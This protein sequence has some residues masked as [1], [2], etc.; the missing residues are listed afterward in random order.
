LIA[1]S[2]PEKTAMQKTTVLLLLAITLLGCQPVRPSEA[3]AAPGAAEDAPA[4]VA[5]PTTAP[6][7]ETTMQNPSNNPLVAQA[8]ADLAGRLNIDAG[9]IEVVSIEEVTWPD[10]A[11]GCPQPG[12]AYAQMLQEGVRI[13]LNAGGTEYDYHSSSDGPPFLCENP[14]PQ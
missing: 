11:L 14:P 3:P 7:E 5:S 1:R 10:A 12:M 8:I 2:T 13:V 6:E 4:P 9:E